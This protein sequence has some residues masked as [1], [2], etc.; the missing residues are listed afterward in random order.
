MKLKGLIVAII[1]LLVTG[2]VAAQQTTDPM[3]MVIHMNGGG[4]KAIDINTVDKLTFDNAIMTVEKKDSSVEQISIP[5]IE[6]FLFSEDPSQQSE[7]KTVTADNARLSFSAESCILSFSSEKSGILS[8]YRISGTKILEYATSGGS[9][10]I[11]L[12]A[13]PA[14]IYVAEYMGQTLKFAKR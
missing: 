13:L 10:Y 3:F 9:S 4:L 2:V 1:S 12:S 7:V 6:S 8:V 14:D 5:D 11:D